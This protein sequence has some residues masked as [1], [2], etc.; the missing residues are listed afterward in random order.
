M[1][2]LYGLPRAM[3]LNPGTAP[4]GG[5]QDLLMDLMF[6]LLGYAV[7]LVIHWLSSRVKSMR[8]GEASA[9]P[10]KT[11]TPPENLANPR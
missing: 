8:S 1:R 4:T 11:A 5:L 6:W 2:A 7:N 10:T 3:T 9:L